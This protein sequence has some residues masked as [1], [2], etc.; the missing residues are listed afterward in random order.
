MTVEVSVGLIITGGKLYVPT[1]ARTSL[2]F[3]QIDPV[4][5]SEATQ[6]NLE[7]AIAQTKEK[8]NPVLSDEQLTEARK[9]KLVILKAT[10]KPSQK[11]LTKNGAWY[12]LTWTEKHISLLMSKLD[13]K[14]RWI[15][16]RD[17]E[18]KLA[19][20]TKITKIANLIM[21]DAILRPEIW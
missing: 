12:N 21:Q 10:K 7:Q 17:K 13:D 4:I 1:L 8:G 16:D 5:I 9:Q 19:R 11:N 18:Q 6:A 3:F 14:D 15:V 20:D 2:G